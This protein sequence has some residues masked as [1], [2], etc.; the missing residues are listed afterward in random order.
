MARHGIAFHMW[1]LSCPAPFKIDIALLQSFAHWTWKIT[2]FFPPAWSEHQE[3]GLLLRSRPSP[4]I[5]HTGSSSIWN[6]SRHQNLVPATGVWSKDSLLTLHVS[7]RG[8]STKVTK[9]PMFNPLSGCRLLRCICLAV[10]CQHHSPV[11]QEVAKQFDSTALMAPIHLQIIRSVIPTSQ[12]LIVKLGLTN[13]AKSP[14]PCKFC[15]L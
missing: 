6:E 15:F 8:F 12:R 13:I 7:Q 1:G 9:S 11:W 2:C 10:H 5:D 4:D 3:P 14:V